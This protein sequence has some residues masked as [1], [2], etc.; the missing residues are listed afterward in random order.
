[1]TDRGASLE[2]RL[3]SPPNRWPGNLRRRKQLIPADTIAGRALVTVIA[4][5]TF[6][7][8][9][10]GGS[11]LLVRD[12]SN[13]WSSLVAK[14][15][16]I[17]IKPGLGRDL[18]KDSVSAANIVRKYVGEDGVRIFSDKESAQLLQP[19]LGSNVE[20]KD[21]PVPRLLLIKRDANKQL[22]LSALRKELL[23]S[24]PNA[25][26]DDHSLWIERL[27]TM[28]QTLV[29]IAL[30]V[31]A[32]VLAAM[33]LA[34]SFATRG[35]MAGNREII[36]V[37]HFVGAEDRFIARQFQRSFLLL[38]L[39]GGITGGV[40]A[41]VGFFA[42]GV[43][44]KGWSASPGGEQVTSLFGS[45]SLGWGGYLIVT[46]I[47]LGMALLTALAS[48]MVVMQHLRRYSTGSGLAS[49]PDS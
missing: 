35:A 25:L 38:G 27:A 15:L 37:L 26:L 19:W 5:M 36:D 20:L 42:A 9:I 2:R 45:F 14:E 31:F 7:A 16:T 39:K 49:L 13:Q 1:M 29:I 34:V 46:I 21:L 4:I 41:L 28:A 23:R 17:Q 33:T 44:L 12:A 22:D 30:V 10:T 8:A 40:L 47:S 3:D 11:A 32:L 6:L 24:V 43:L 18:E 48:R